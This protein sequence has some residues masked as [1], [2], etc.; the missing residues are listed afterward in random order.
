MPL[1]HQPCS[2]SPALAPV[3]DLVLVP[4]GFAREEVVVGHIWVATARLPHG[5]DSILVKFTRRGQ[6]EELLHLLES[7]LQHKQVA[8]LLGTAVVGVQ[9]LLEEMSNPEA[10]NHVMMARH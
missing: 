3:C 7:I 2:L 5:L 8:T 6:P 10:R 9:V 4:L 1:S